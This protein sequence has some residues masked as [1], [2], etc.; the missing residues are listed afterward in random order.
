[1]VDVVQAVKD[2]A[3]GFK[4]ANTL[5]RLG[6]DILESYMPLGRLTTEG[7]K[8]ARELYGDKYMDASPDIRRRA[9][10]MI[11][12]GEREQARADVESDAVAAVGEFFGTLA[13]PSALLPVGQSVSAGAKAGFGYGALFSSADQFANE[14]EVDLGEAAVMGG[15][16]GLIGGTFNF[17]VNAT[18]NALGR[19]AAAMQQSKPKVRISNRKIEAIEEYSTSARADGVPE[20]AIPAYV[21]NKM[22]VDEDLVR[23]WTASS[24][25]RP[26]A[27]DEAGLSSYA[28]MKRDIGSWIADNYEEVLTPIHTR[29]DQL[30]PEIAAGVRRYEFNVHAMNKQFEDVATPF[31]QQFQ[32]MSEEGQNRVALHLMNGRYKQART[33]AVAQGMD[34]SSV[35]AVQKLMNDIGQAYKDKG[36]SQG[37]V[38]DY[39]PRKVS[40]W[41]A[42]REQLGRNGSDIDVMF[43]QHARQTGRVADDLRGDERAWLIENYM[44]GKHVRVQG[45]TGA[46]RRGYEVTEEMLTNYESPVAALSNYLSRA[47]DDLSVSELF[48]TGA[49]KPKRKNM[50]VGDV[51]IE[52]FDVEGNVTAMLDKMMKTDDPAYGQVASLLQARLNMTR[53]PTMGVVNHLRSLGY[54]NTIGNPMSALTQIGDLGVSAV[55]H[56]MRPTL[57]GI[58]GKKHVD[59]A[60][61]GIKTAL[62]ADYSNLSSLSK[63]LNWVL[64]KSGFAAIDKFGK[65]VNLNAALNKNRGVAN[66]SKEAFTEKWGTM[67]GDEVDN[68]YNSVRNGEVNEN[69]RMMLFS[70]LAD[71]QPITMSEMPKWYL[72]HPNGRLFYMLKTFTLKQLDLLRRNVVDNAKKGNVGDA[73]KFAAGYTTLFAGM[74]ATIDEIKHG[75]TGRGFEIE[76]IP[77]NYINN[78]LGIFLVNRYQGEQLRSGDVV[79]TAMDMVLPPLDYANAIVRD[80]VDSAS[81]LANGTPQSELDWRI[82]GEIPLI[83]PWWGSIMDGAFGQSQVDDRIQEDEQTRRDSSGA[84]LVRS[85]IQ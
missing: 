52:S 46:Q 25:K 17:G 64:D 60:E 59:L 77:D 85:L 49:K 24:S 67:F 21:A 26:I 71:T 54:M 10:R 76:D 70:E 2:F 51:N 27:M 34:A 82:G 6:G 8:S 31:M 55:V 38:K 75:L 43:T 65:N 44:K 16:G 58:F 19:R 11:R 37:T 61:L 30:S 63:Q 48:V 84:A 83:G 39:F 5:E 62:D 56:G 23:L 3:G 33:A 66:R 45:R 41:K 18:L 72:D 50:K 20:E 12:E 4:G 68:L 14:G 1:M 73:V 81:A 78:L 79:D 36:L 42:L 28:K 13:T 74:G 29:L 69:V 22:D 35:D 40:D 9:L 57:R 15:V 32:N 80:V 53:E 7:Y 47:A